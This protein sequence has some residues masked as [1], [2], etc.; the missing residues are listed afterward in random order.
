MTRLFRMLATKMVKRSSDIED[1]Y[2]DQD[3]VA[4]H[5]LNYD[6]EIKTYRESVPDEEYDAM[7]VAGDVKIDVS[8][9]PPRS[10]APA[11]QDR[12]PAQE[13]LLKRLAP[14]LT[15][16]GLA[17]G[18]LWWMDNRTQPEVLP[19]KPEVEQPAPEKPD[20]DTIGVFEKDQ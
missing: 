8:E 7:M 20:K 2:V 12:P 4:N 14:W 9:P 3:Y 18:G 15:A 5:R 13:S 10:P 1:H 17:A 16:A 6:G 11:P 19:K